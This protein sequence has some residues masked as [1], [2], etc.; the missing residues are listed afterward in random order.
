MWDYFICVNRTQGNSFFL[1]SP[2][3][4]QLNTDEMTLSITHVV[5]CHFS[6]ISRVRLLCHCGEV[7][8]KDKNM[9]LFLSFTFFFQSLK[10]WFKSKMVLRW[11]KAWVPV[12]LTGASAFRTYLVDPVKHQ[13]WRLRTPGSFPRHSFQWLFYLISGVEYHDINLDLRPFI[14][15]NRRRTVKVRKDA[16]QLLRAI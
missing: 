6:E 13:H 3:P 7:K 16:E 15:F 5:G 1:I 14:K 12:M 11:R 10:G 8:T 4:P 2:I 9:H